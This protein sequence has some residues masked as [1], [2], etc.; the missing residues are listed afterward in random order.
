MGNY[1]LRY[2]PLPETTEGM[3]LGTQLVVAEHGVVRFSLPA[4][5]ALTEANLRQLAAHRAEFLCIREEDG[6]SEEERQK[7]WEMREQRLARIFR[8]A[9]LGQPAVAGLYQAV[10]AY[11]RS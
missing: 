10:L 6:R 11:R 8:A 4:E 7:E 2:L 3:V 9:D 1:R 5:H